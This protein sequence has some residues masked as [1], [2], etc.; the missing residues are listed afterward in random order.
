MTDWQPVETMP[1][2]FKDGRKVILWARR[3][4]F[5]DEAF[6][7]WLARYDPT[8]TTKTVNKEPASGWISVEGQAMLE[9]GAAFLDHDDLI[10]THWQPWPDDGPR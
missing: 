9:Y 2:E 8:W 10:P 7:T 6:E 5:P 4:G 3:C 1:P